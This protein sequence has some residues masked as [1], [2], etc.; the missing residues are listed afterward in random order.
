MSD[1][2]D[3]RYRDG[4]TDGYIDSG[5]GSE[6]EFRELFWEAIDMYID[7]DS[8]PSVVDMGCGDMRLW[9]D[10][11]IPIHYLG[12]DSSSVIIDKNR[13]NFD[14]VYF[15]HK[16][17]HMVTC[18]PKRDIVMCISTLF[19]IMSKSVYNM[20][21]TNLCKCSKD[22]IFVT[23]WSQTPF[24]DGGV[25]D[26]KY[27]HYRNLED[28]MDIFEYW[29]FEFVDLHNLGGVNTLYVFRKQQ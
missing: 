17:I 7:W 14:G 10:R 9:D 16:Y 21:L 13:A 1:Y 18:V 28:S 2:W 4:T 19:H 6:G 29:G 23:A 20:T 5:E 26:G 12:V 8:E 27:Q 15:R 3:T 11:D 25:H 22:Y 24:K